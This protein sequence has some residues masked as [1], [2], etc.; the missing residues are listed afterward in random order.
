RQII[1]NMHMTATVAEW[2]KTHGRHPV[3]A[4]GKMVPGIGKTK[5]LALPVIAKRI[6]A[7]EEKPI[8]PY[9]VEES[10]VECV[11]R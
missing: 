10:E 2:Y 1:E 6:L 11:G 4:K 5:S 3:Y 8:S 9:L 7:E